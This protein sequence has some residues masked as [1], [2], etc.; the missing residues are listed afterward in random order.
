MFQNCDI[1]AR[2]PIE[3]QENTITAQGRLSANDPGGFSFQDCTVV[4]DEDLAHAAN[5]PCRPT[6]AARGCHSG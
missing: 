6:S 2:M 3:G 5:V 4:V 1:R